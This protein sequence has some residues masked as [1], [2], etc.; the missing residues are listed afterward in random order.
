MPTEEVTR[1]YDGQEFL[2]DNRWCLSRRGLLTGVG[3]LGAA[4]LLSACGAGDSPTDS[5]AAAAP[6][7]VLARA[8]DVPVGGGTVTA[9]VLVVQPE[10]GTFR[11]YD[12]TCPHQGVRVGAPRDGVVTCPA[13]NSTFSPSDG[14]RL[15]GPATKGLTEIPVRLDGD[16][17]TRA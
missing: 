1:M 3:A 7:T 9:G 17:I 16:N 12:A 10:A 4:G 11:A 6:G 15:G 5:Q 2:R 13:H 14:A 8:G